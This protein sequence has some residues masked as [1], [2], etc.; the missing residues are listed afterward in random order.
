MHTPL[1]SAPE[2]TKRKVCNWKLKS[3]YIKS[4]YVFRI[5]LRAHGG[6]TVS[7]RKLVIG[8]WCAPL[9]GLRRMRAPAA[10]AWVPIGPMCM[11]WAACGWLFGTV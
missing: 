2:T 6:R 11:D 5:A 8:A 1:T 9:S 7:L 3:L 10:V 4:M